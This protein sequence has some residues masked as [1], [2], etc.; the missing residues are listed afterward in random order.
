MLRG[1]NWKTFPD[2]FLH[3]LKEPFG[4]Y[5]VTVAP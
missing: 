4:T 5:E 1:Q 3:E 2:F